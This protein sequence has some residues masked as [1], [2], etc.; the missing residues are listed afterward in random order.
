VRKPI[1]L[2]TASIKELNEL[3]DDIYG[4]KFNPLLFNTA[5]DDL[6]VG[7][8]LADVVTKVNEVLAMLRTANILLD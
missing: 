1:E 5:I 6:A 4:R 7:A 8:S 3:F 2:K